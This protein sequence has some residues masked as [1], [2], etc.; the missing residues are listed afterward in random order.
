M[1]SPYSEPKPGWTLRFGRLGFWA[2]WWTP[3][4]HSGRGPYFSLGLGLVAIYR[5]Y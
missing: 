4:W 5:G 1:K 3:T 2:S